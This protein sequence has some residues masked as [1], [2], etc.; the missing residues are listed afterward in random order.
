MQQ[1]FWNQEEYLESMLMTTT[2]LRQFKQVQHKLNN[3]DTVQSLTIRTSAAPTPA[4]THGG[5][6]FMSVG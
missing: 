1:N 2:D 4:L 6:V 3:T 5:P